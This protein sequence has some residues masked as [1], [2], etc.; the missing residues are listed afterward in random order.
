MKMPHLKGA[1]KLT[2]FG[3]TKMCIHRSAAFVLDVPG[4]ELCFGVFRAA[5]P[6]EIELQPEASREPFIHAWAEFRGAVYAPTTIEAM[7]GLH[8]IDP[9]YYYEI[10]GATEIRRMPRPKLLKVA[11]AIGL[12][13]H[14]R[15]GKPAR[16]SVGGTLLDAMGIEYRV[17]PDGGLVPA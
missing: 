16:A 5:T 15:H 13:Q 9:A 8:P 3:Q 4:A 12:S 1:M 14:L 17:S 2:G 11:K 6:E 7:G 10:N